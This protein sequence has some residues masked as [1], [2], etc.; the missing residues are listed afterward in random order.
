MVKHRKTF[1]INLTSSL[2]VVPF[3]KKKLPTLRIIFSR[4]IILL[5]SNVANLARLLDV[6]VWDLDSNHA[7]SQ[8]DQDYHRLDT[9]HAKHRLNLFLIQLLFHHLILHTFCPL[10]VHSPLTS[11]HILKL[12]WTVRGLGYSSIFT[13]VFRS[14]ELLMICL[15]M[16][17]KNCNFLLF[18]QVSLIL[19]SGQPV[20]NRK[21][22]SNM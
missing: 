21:I 7:A 12:N 18:D 3:P 22:S 4:I 17:A 14:N 6:K 20:C 9:K 1:A 13:I 15:E 5:L 8:V 19:C 16:I 11:L 2:K 10:V